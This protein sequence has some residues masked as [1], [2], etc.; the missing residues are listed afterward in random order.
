MSI[1][2]GKS[3]KQKSKRFPLS[4]ILLMLG[5]LVVSV[6]GWLRLQQSLVLW[7]IL[8]LIEIWP[9]PAYLAVSGAAWGIVGLVTVIALFFKKTWAARWTMGAVLFLA[10]WYWIDHLVLVQ[11]EA[12]QANRVFTV[13]VT[14]FVVLYTFAVMRF[15]Y[16]P[17]RVE[18]FQSSSR[19]LLEN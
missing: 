6:Y 1:S 18:T 14:V 2:P 15:R 19:E 16:H 7:E 11:S 8:S 3:R 9:G 10:A 4:L 12:A 13:L 5:F 17:M